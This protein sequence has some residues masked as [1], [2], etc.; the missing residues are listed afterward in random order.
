MKNTKIDANGTETRVMVDVVND[1]AY[2]SLTDIAKYKKP[3]NTFIAVANWMRNHSKI[4]FLV[5]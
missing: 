2:I 4:S 5:S 1:E 3:D